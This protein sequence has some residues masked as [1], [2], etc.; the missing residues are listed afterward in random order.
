MISRRKFLSNVASLLPLAGSDLQ[1]SAQD[2]DDP[3]LDLKEALFG[4]TANL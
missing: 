3:A 2:A 4:D 1:A